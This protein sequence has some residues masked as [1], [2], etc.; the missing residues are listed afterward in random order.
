MPKTNLCLKLLS[1]SECVSYNHL[2][3]NVEDFVKFNNVK[4]VEVRNKRHLW[5]HSL[6]EKAMFNT[7]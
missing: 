4:D 2:L 3:T 6:Q 1:K 7:N 5:L